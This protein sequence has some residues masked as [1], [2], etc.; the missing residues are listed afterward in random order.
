MK[1]IFRALNMFR[2]L[3]SDS[4]L[5]RT[6]K[7]DGLEMIQCQPANKIKL[8]MNLVLVVGFEG[9]IDRG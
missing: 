6:Q 7:M 8:N 9:I 3:F 4:Y 5:F 1:S 2:N